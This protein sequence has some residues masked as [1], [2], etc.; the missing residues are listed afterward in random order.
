MS[1]QDGGYLETAA[2]VEADTDVESGVNSKPQFS[3][4]GTVELQN[5]PL[6][7]AWRKFTYWWSSALLIFALFV[8]FY[9]MG[10]QWN[11]PPWDP[12]D[13]HPALDIC[14]FIVMLTWISLLEGC[15]IS[16]VGLQNVNVEAYKLTHPRAYAVCNLA[17]KGPNVERFLVGRQFLLLFNGFLVSRIGGG[18][19]EDFYIGDW[20]WNVEATQFF[21]LNAT[22]L[23]VVIV[24]PGQLVT[25]L[26]AMDKMLGFLNLK[27]YAYYTVLMP[28]MFVESIGLTHS[29]YMLKDVL[30][31]V[32]GVDPQKGDPSKKMDKNFLYYFRVLISVS[33]V[34][35]S[36]TFIVK[37]LYMSQTNA[38]DGP[39]WRKL[40]GYGAVIVGIFFLFLMACAEGLQ[41]SALALAN[42]H[43]AAFKK[44]SPLAYR[45]CNLLYAGRNMNAFL[46][47]RQFLTA[48]CMVLLGRVTSYTGSE[49]V[50]SG[51]DWGMGKGFN[52][53]LLQTGFLG[54]ILVVNVAQLASQVMA[55]IFPITFI[56][57][58]FLYLLLQLMLLVETCGV[59]NACW[60]LAALVDNLLKI[61]KDPFEDD[62]DV[63]TFNHNMIDRKKS[64][65]LPV[66]N[67]ATPF[68]LHQPTEFTYRVS[69]I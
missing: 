58:H 29:A 68:D 54:A 62:K 20:H 2:V 45:T 61:P 5:H 67:N 21:W 51:D 3:N 19:Q 39:G 56:N 28:C 25:Q 18:K 13:S 12:S 6:A 24:V 33:A 64:L 17:H 38:T 43:T 16:I 53:G 47:G 37:G 42:T 50:I 66:D 7:V 44:T 63:D 57:N 32:T 40:P 27:F 34:I 60:P 15:Q 35:F 31:K 41:V 8:V 49:G 52:E 9:G 22:L 69:Y 55:S 1:N 59:V 26:I 36:G 48:M 46:V 11:N 10:K 23:M 30:V 65:G 4:G 14:L